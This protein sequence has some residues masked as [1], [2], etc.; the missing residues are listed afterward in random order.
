MNYN[1]G[2]SR[3][4]NITEGVHLQSDLSSDINN[5]YIIVVST[6]EQVHST[7]SKT[8]E[9]F[10]LNSRKICVLQA[11]NLHEA[12]S[13]A[14]RHPDLVLV[15]IDDNVQVNGSYKLFV[16]Y[17]NNQLENRNCYITFKE[18][19]IRT[20]S[21]VSGA[22]V[23]NGTSKEL[24]EFFQARERLIEITR[25]IMMTSDM[26]QKIVGTGY[27]ETD[28]S[29]LSES[30]DHKDRNI[31]ASRDKLY[32]TL[33]HD[34]KAPVGNIKVILDFLTNE[35]DLLDQE[36]SKDL[37]SRVRESANNVHE[38]LEDFLFWSRMFKQD[39]HFNPHK[40]DLELAVRENILIL[41][42]AAAVKDINFN[43]EMPANTYVLADE[44]MLNTI[45]RNLLYNSIK[46]T[47]FGGNVHITAKN[48]HNYILIT[49]SDDGIGI[50]DEDIARLFKPDEHFTTNGTAREKGS[51]FGLVLVKDLIEKNGGEIRI[52]SQKNNGTAISFSLP[53]WKNNKS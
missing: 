40:I 3:G 36:S 45:F 30:G 42:S 25:M 21:P 22:Q 16:D 53:P 44:P 20:V 39:I 47:P 18:N 41:K 14:D 7:L 32:N 29:E 5:Y 31:V 15:V 43:Y 37:L 48:E 8:L 13:M 27:P 2:T 10:S 11:F 26:E 24:A 50:S 51:G 4:Y 38:M 9:H 33:A 17:V 1:Q 23:M 35:P 19:L 49:I 6:N 46:F 28:N 34:L 12:K 52:D